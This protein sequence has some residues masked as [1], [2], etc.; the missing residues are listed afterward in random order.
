MFHVAINKLK[1]STEDFY[2]GNVPVNLQIYIDLVN[3]LMR[4]YLKKTLAYL[5]KL[6]VNANK[7][8]NGKGDIFNI[9]RVNF[10]F[11]SDDE[12][13][14]TLLSLDGKDLDNELQKR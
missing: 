11:D 3:N 13:G 12:S 9:D 5:L 2:T 14:F 10:N 8:Y 7:Y 6:L 4:V 1:T